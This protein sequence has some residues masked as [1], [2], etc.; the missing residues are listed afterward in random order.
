MITDNDI[1]QPQYLTRGDNKNG[2][3][4]YTMNKNQIMKQSM[5]KQVI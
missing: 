5:L 3:I 1:L 4:E 2:K